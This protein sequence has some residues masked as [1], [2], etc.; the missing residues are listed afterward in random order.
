MSAEPITAISNITN[1]WFYYYQSS[2]SRF[3]SIAI[4]S[5]IFEIKY[6]LLE[7]IVVFQIF[8]FSDNFYQFYSLFIWTMEHEF[9][10]LSYHELW[11]IYFS[12]NQSNAND[13]TDMGSA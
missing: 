9:S 2:L 13:D 10:K 7:T 3:L 4:I 1:R 5:V 6:E 8:C 11:T 12:H